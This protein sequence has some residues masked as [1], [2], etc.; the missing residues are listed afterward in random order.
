MASLGSD[1]QGRPSILH[2]QASQDRNTASGTQFR[3]TPKAGGYFGSS[4]K[5]SGS[6]NVVQLYFRETYMIKECTS[7]VLQGS[8]QD[9]ELAALLQHIRTHRIVV[10]MKF[11]KVY[12]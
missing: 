10:P 4:G 2:K 9:P 7:A 11:Q 12:I 6:R 1:K 5:H 3:G 8:I